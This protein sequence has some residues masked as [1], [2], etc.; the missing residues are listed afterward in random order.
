PGAASTL[1]DASAFC[2]PAPW[3]RAPHQAFRPSMRH[4]RAERR[5]HG[6]RAMRARLWILAFLL[7]PAGPAHAGDDVV[8]EPALSRGLPILDAWWLDARTSGIVAGSARRVLAARG[9]LSLQ[10][11][12]G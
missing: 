7:L 11:H 4:T 6:P 10:G 9:E 5:L 8:G 3:P 12:I 1:P 2:Q